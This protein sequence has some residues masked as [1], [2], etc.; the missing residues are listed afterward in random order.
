[1]NEC[2]SSIS[3][4]DGAEHIWWLWLDADEFPH[5]PR[6][7]TIRDYLS[8]L[9][10]SFRIV[11]T[12]YIN[13]YPADAPQDVSGFHPLDFQLLGEELTTRT[14]WSWHRKHPLQRLTE[15][16]RDPVRHR[17]ASR[18]F[19]RAPAVRAGRANPYSPFPFPPEGGNAQPTARSLYADSRT[20]QPR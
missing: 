14:C 20:D 16:P 12:R 19:D 6:G 2:V 11:G 13:H 5:G 10:S 1:M 4:A 17:N 7:L 8:T 3:I 15:P 18:L 9:D